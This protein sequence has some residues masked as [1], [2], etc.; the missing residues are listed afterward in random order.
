[1]NEILF[2]WDETK[3][4]VCHIVINHNHHPIYACLH[5]KTLYNDTFLLILIKSYCHLVH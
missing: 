4:E 5:F 1:M 2:L 3:E